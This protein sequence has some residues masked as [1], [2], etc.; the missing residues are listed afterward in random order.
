M[1]TKEEEDRHWREC[2]GSTCFQLSRRLTHEEEQSV[3]K[4]D[5]TVS[6]SEFGG[7][8]SRRSC[9]Y[10]FHKRAASLRSFLTKTF[11]DQIIQKEV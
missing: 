5:Q 10:I 11:G 6:I 2:H 1:W 9:I 7:L 3:K 4:F 8:G